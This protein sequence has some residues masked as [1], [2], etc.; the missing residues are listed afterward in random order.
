MDVIAV[1]QQEMDKYGVRTDIQSF[2]KCQSGGTVF[3][4]DS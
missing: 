2:K 1:R 3:F 4:E